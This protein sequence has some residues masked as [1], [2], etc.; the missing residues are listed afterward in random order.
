MSADRDG[1]PAETLEEPA[2]TTAATSGPTG[3]PESE[4][5]RRETAR[6][7]A[8]ALERVRVVSHLLDEA[9]RVPGTN[10]RVGLDPILGI[11]PVG[12]DVVAFLFSIY[13]ILEAARFDL[14][15]WTIAKMLVLVAIDAVVGSIPLVGTLFDAVWKANEWNRRTLERHLAVE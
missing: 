9:I 4:T 6:G 2:A 7:E 10:Y 15:T 5:A 8:A 1:D 13:P 3:R 11:L 12:G 14:P